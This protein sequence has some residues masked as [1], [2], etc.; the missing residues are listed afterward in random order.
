MLI[1]SPT[2]SPDAP[3]ITT[4]PSVTLTEKFWPSRLARP[5]P[6][7]SLSASLWPVCACGGKTQNCKFYANPWLTIFCI[8]LLFLQIQPE[9]EKRRA[10]SGPHVAH[11]IR[12]DGQ[13]SPELF[14]GPENQ[15]LP[16][17]RHDGWALEMGAGCGIK[18]DGKYLCGESHVQKILA[19]ILQI[20]P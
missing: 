19:K 15:P 20:N 1:F 4:V 2:F 12:R 11:L 13:P 6:L 9:M 17:T 8:F 18:H 14:G 5:S 16:A 10:E 7:W 3:E